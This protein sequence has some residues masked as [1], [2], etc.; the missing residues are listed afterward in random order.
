MRLLHDLLADQT[1]DTVLA[2]TNIGER[3]DLEK[4]E[5]EKDEISLKGRKIDIQLNQHH[6]CHRSFVRCCRRS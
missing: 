3:P 4:D 2:T 5:I 1:D 6:L